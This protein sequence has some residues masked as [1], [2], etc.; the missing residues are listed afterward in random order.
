MLL[1]SSLRSSW[2]HQVT[3]EDMEFKEHPAAHF[4]VVL[5]QKLSQEHIIFRLRILKF[6]ALRIFFSCSPTKT[7]NLTA[8]GRGTG[9]TWRLRT[10]Y[11][12]LWPTV[13]R[14]PI[15][16]PV[17][18]STSED[19]SGPPTWRCP[20]PPSKKSARGGFSLLLEGRHF[21]VSEDLS[22][23]LALPQGVL[24]DLDAGHELKDWREQQPFS[25]HLRHRQLRLRTTQEMRDQ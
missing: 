19:P 10:R 9:G 23:V 7:T 24:Q 12:G 11:Q 22:A 5:H 3:I 16:C 18:A 14:R 20:P 21:Q 2:I 6:L 4:A 15:L 25:M 1:G 13:S 17:A 8:L